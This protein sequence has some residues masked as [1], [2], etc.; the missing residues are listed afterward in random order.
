MP[1]VD[2]LA[3]VAIATDAV[4]PLDSRHVTFRLGFATSEGAMDVSVASTIRLHETPS[5]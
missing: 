5:S 4:D 3:S 1:L 2:G